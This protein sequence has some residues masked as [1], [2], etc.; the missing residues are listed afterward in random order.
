MGEDIE[1]LREIKELSSRGVAVIFYDCEEGHLH[2]GIPY[3]VSA[4]SIEDVVIRIY[5]DSEVEDV[6]RQVD[7]AKR[8]IL[9]L[10]DI[11]KSQREESRKEQQKSRY[12]DFYRYLSQHLNFDKNSSLL[13]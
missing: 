10:L 3:E 2:H 13:K 9:L 5:S 12:T 6:Q 1:L 4:S 7:E 11:F 8:Q